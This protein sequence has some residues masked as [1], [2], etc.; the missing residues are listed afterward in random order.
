MC[1]LGLVIA[2]VAEVCISAEFFLVKCM[3]ITFAA[4]ALPLRIALNICSARDS[5]C[6]ITPL[7]I[8][9]RITSPIKQLL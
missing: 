5:P 4:P 8:P 9:K 7:I 3:E 6:R 2:S 1:V